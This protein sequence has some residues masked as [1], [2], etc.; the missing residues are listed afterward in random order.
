MPPT[1]SP[2]AASTRRRACVN[3]TAAKS[4][5]LPISPDECD[6]CHRLGKTC[7]YGNILTKRRSPTG[8]SR[9]RLLENKLNSIVS[10]INNH[11]PQDAAL[12]GLLSQIQS[13]TR[14]EPQGLS[15][16]INAPTHGLTRVETSD[17]V[18]RGLV[19]LEL[20]RT[21]LHDYR[22]KAIHHFPFVIVSPEVDANSLRLRTPFLFLCIM[23]SMMVKD[24]PLQRQIGQEIRIQF[25]QRLL[26]ESE[27]SL[28][29]LQGL[30]VYLAWYQYHFLP[31]NQQLV[32]IAQLCVA[33]VHSLGLDQ[34]PQN[35]KRRVDL[36]PPETEQHRA[37][38]RSLE[39]LRAL[40]GTYCTASWIATKFRTRC[41]MPHTKY[42]QQ[43]CA[44]L[45]EQ[46]E[47]SSDQ[48][49]P[50]FVRANELSR[51][52]C[53]IF[54]YDDLD[55]TD[56]RGDHVSNL[57][58]Q[59]FVNELDVLEKSIA[60]EIRHDTIALDLEL[61]H[62]RTLISE[63]ALH[64]EFWSNPTFASPM[65]SLSPALRWN[66]LRGLAQNCRALLNRVTACSDDETWYL[67]FYTYA[68]I[69]RVLSCLTNLD[70]VN[71]N[72]P[73]EDHDDVRTFGRQGVSFA[74]DMTPIEREADF[75]TS[76][77]QLQQKLLNMAIVIAKGESDCD[78]MTMF[79]QM[80]GDVMAAYENRARD[81]RQLDSAR[82]AAISQD[83]G[84][85]VAQGMGTIPFGTTIQATR[86]NDFLG[87]FV[88]GLFDLDEDNEPGA[89]RGSG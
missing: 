61:Y 44:S 71:L 41:A 38:A 83:S 25:H 86:K 54:A 6:R 74:W 51:R 26:L 43:S 70:N 15:R 21:L 17:I 49:I 72:P 60:N 46:S 36:G 77:T 62:I 16:R 89:L 2:P 58:V 18:D 32:Q 39:E 40:L 22:K 56:I 8:T 5:C 31:E 34:N 14:S 80:V 42:I 12:A 68:K 9:V 1:S 24:C 55:N 45:A 19:S 82:S 65:N 10:L 48:L 88:G 28:E 50:H 7:V 66:M 67:T 84:V 78:I 4:K 30:L 75:P 47:L 69:C 35:H 59:A 13:Q 33:Q 11:H 52:I 79:S 63:I 3:C 73:R 81:R 23:G 37:S 64:Q 27:T 53:N 87:P 20:A 85:S 29:L 76:V 57:T